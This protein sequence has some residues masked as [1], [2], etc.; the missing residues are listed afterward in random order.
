MRRVGSEVFPALIYV[1]GIPPANVKATM[2]LK[3]PPDLIRAICGHYAQCVVGP[4]AGALTPSIIPSGIRVTD[5]TMMPCQLQM[6]VFVGAG[7]TTGMFRE[8]ALIEQQCRSKGDA[9]CVYDF[10]LA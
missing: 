3:E 4:E 1:L 8:R 10:Q 6:G 7:T 2:G 5:T 9:A